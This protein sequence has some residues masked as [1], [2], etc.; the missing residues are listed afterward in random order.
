MYIGVS[1]CHPSSVHVCW[2]C[3]H[4]CDC[5]PFLFQHHLSNR[6]RK[7]LAKAARKQRRT[8]ERKENRTKP[9]AVM[10]GDGPDTTD[11]VGATA[12]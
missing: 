5:H 1:V 2:D 8:Q 11:P 12:I 9:A 6:E 7:E 10:K 4:R 3:V